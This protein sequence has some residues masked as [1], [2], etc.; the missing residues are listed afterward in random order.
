M[1]DPH[2]FGLHGTSLRTTGVVSVVDCDPVTAECVQT[3]WMA[4]SYPTV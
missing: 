3:S 1:C 2:C 4:S